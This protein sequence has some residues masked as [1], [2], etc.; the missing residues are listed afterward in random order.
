MSYSLPTTIQIG[1]NRYKIRND[2]DFRM[3]LDCFE[4]LGDIELDNT[5]RIEAA[6]IIFYEDIDTIEE[7]FALFK[8]DML[9]AAIKEMF[10]FLI[11]AFPISAQKTSIS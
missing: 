1:Q 11:A 9:A 8:G 6:L 2:G 7:I 5:G 10:N 3:V 4:A